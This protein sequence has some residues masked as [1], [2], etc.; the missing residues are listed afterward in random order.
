MINYSINELE[1]L[2]G[3]K[4]HTIRM[5]EKRYHV[6]SPQRTE[7]NIRYYNDDDLK[8]LLN[9]STLNRHGIKI[10][11]I[12][13]MNEETIRE[14][15]MDLS[16]ATGNNESLINNLIVSMIEFSEESFEHILN[17]SILKLGFERTVTEVLY[18][19]LE[20]IG[21]LW[22]TGS[23]NPAQEHF[24]TNLIRQKLII[25]ID[26]QAAKTRAD[27]KTF[28]LFLPEQEFHELGLLFYTFL[29]KKNGHRVVYL[30]QSVPFEDLQEVVKVRNSDY[31]FTY[32]VAALRQ[33]DIP[34]YLRQLSTAFPKKTIF[35]TGIQVQYTTL[36]LPENI[37]VI[38]NGEEFKSLLKSI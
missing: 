6:F 13:T 19:F 2:T 36:E 26:G 12:A 5:W 28:L 27:A 24:I 8:K 35:I 14:K 7:T 20:K 38:K 9:I 3:I 1:K 31:L 25:A 16:G 11:K 21:V 23:V 10:S 30:G 32:F 37:V 4:A 29:L 18:P 15:V 34:A 22:Q 33:E 17:S